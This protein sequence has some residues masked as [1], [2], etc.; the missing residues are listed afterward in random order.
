MRSRNNTFVRKSAA[1]RWVF[2]A[3]VLLAAA[4][5]AAPL[6]RAGAANPQSGTIAP[7]SPTPVTWKGTG[8]GV[9]PALGGESSCVEGQNCDFFKLTISGQPSDWVAAGKQVHVEINWLSNS[10]DYDL[11]VHKDSPDGPVVAT[12]GAGGTTKEAVDLNPRRPNIGTGDFYVH[13]VYFTVA[14]ADQ[15]T[16]TATVVS[17]PPAAPA[18]AQ[19]SGIAPRYQNVTPPAAGPATLGLSAGEPSIGSNWKTG[20]A[21]FQAILQTLRVTFD[22]SCQ[23][24]PKATWEDRTAPNTSQQSFDPILFTDREQGRT[25]VS[26]LLFNPVLNS[27]SSYTDDDGNTWVPSQGGG[28]GQGVDHQTIGGGPYHAPLTGVAYPNAIY[29]CSQDLVAAN[30]SRSDDGGRTYGPSIPMYDSATSGCAGIHGHV[31]VGRDGTVYVPNKDCEGKQ[32]VVVSEDNGVTWKIVPVE[33]KNVTI[34]TSA[35]SDP[36]IAVG[37]GDKVKDTLGNPV[38]RVY[39]G[40]ADANIDPVVAVSDDRGKTWKNVQ[41]VGASLGISNVVFPA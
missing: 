40:Y 22:D 2:G 23:T 28:P 34:S 4:V 41:N 19:A 3:L 1:P 18:A 10:D 21:M 20:R 8:T 15:Y 38:G 32:A 31:K 26:Q 17:A 36:S 12:S 30:C 33:Q 11:Y 37:R 24:T 27:A 35:D 5:C 16:G 6:F 25:I 13:A 39:L 9:P 29:Y 7:T 14:A